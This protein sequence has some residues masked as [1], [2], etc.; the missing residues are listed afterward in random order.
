MPGTGPHPAVASDVL[1]FFKQIDKTVPPQVKAFVAV[2][3]LQNSLVSLDVASLDSEWGE[4]A[5][6]RVPETA[7]LFQAD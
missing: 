5:R 6:S 3:M 2:G 4:Q 1:R 7:W